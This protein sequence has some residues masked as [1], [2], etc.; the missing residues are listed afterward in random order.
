M[1][2]KTLNFAGQ[3][4]TARLFAVV[5]VLGALF[6]AGCSTHIGDMQSPIALPADA[7]ERPSVPYTY[8]AVHDMPPERPAPV[9][10]DEQ[11]KKM[12]ADLVSARNRQTGGPPPPKPPAKKP[13]G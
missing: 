13:K 6:L 10:T 9:L 3:I 1:H 2:R 12:E 4:G 8:P 5:A 11:Q 7:P